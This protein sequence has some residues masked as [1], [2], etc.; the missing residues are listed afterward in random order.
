M[1]DDINKTKFCKEPVPKKFSYRPKENV[2][3]AFDITRIVKSKVV[4]CENK[5][6]TQKLTQHLF[7]K[8]R[9]RGNSHVQR[10][11]QIL[12]IFCVTRLDTKL[13]IIHK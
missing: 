1:F 11:T 6:Y 7:I 9:I 8:R 2:K 5:R 10:I 4:T 12:T 3:L 13:N